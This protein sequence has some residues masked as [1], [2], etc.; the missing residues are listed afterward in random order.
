MKRAFMTKKHYDFI[1]GVL[2]DLVLSEDPV[3]SPHPSDV[4]DMAVCFADAL[5]ETNPLFKRDLFL[6]ACGVNIGTSDTSSS[7]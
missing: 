1:A 2:R 7:D 3:P 6:A 5:E 4:I